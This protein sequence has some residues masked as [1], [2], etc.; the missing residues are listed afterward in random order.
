MEIRVNL[1]QTEIKVVSLALKNKL[2]CDMRLKFG[3]FAPTSSVSASIYLST[4]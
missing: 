2:A 3:R 1:V 4:R